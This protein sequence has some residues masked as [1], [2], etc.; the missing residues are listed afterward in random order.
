MRLL[1]NLYLYITLF[2]LFTFIEKSFS[3]TNYEIIKICKKEKRSP[4]CI[5]NLRE[6]RD[7]LEKGNF[8]KIPVIPYKN[9]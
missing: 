4:T 7:N 1:L 9:N 3:L 8:I 5:K 2:F 6:K